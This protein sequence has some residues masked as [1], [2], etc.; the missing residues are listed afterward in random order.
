MHPILRGR[1]Q[2]TVNGTERQGVLYVSTARKPGESDASMSMRALK[3]AVKR[4]GD[5]APICIRN[6]LNGEVF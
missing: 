6:N 3:M 5:K 1:F 2:F 4:S